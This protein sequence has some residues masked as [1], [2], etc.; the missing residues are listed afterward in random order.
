MHFKT[1]GNSCNTQKISPNASKSIDNSNYE[2]VAIDEPS[3]FFYDTLSGE[4]TLR[5]QR[6]KDRF[7]LTIHTY[8]P[9]VIVSWYD[10]E[11]MIE[12]K[13]ILLLAQFI[14]ASLPL[15]SMNIGISNFG[16][17]SFLVEG[18]SCAYN[19]INTYLQPALKF[20]KHISNKKNIYMNSK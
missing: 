20:A 18:I 10:D 17:H 15:R 8:S 3:I 1:M 9:S 2:R 13:L 4:E 5:V 12:E 11:N 7:E 19:T 16:S 6:F 14:R